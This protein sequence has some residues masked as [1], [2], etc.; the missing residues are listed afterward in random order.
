V[1]DY[2]R[3]N[4]PEHWRAATGAARVGLARGERGGHFQP[5]KTWARMHGWRP[6][7]ATDAEGE[8]G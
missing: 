7:K 6:N 3:G 1:R 2:M 8:H 4:V 5:T